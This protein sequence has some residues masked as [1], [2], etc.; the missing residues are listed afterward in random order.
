MLKMYIRLADVA[1]QIS[2]IPQNSLKIRIYSSST[3]SKIMDLGANQ[4]L[5]C[6]FLLVINSNYG[7]ITVFKILMHL[8]R[9]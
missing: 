4:K 1:S 8:A 2:E 6:N 7:R 5:I 9:K 3:S